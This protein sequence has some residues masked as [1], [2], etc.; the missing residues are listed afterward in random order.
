M[1]IFNS[2]V[3]L[4]EGSLFRDGESW[5]QHV[6]AP[7]SKRQQ[8]ERCTP[9]VYWLYLHSVVSPLVP[10]Y[11]LGSIWLM[12]PK[13]NV[14]AHDHHQIVSKIPLDLLQRSDSNASTDGSSISRYPLNQPLMGHQPSFLI[15]IWESSQSSRSRIHMSSRENPVHLSNYYCH[16]YR[17]WRGAYRLTAF[18]TAFR[19]HLFQKCMKRNTTV[20]FNHSH[21]DS[22]ITHA[23]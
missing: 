2:Y 12:T 19:A 18:H 17:F 4:P 15:F 14:I 20:V 9:L 6:P 23:Y 5:F 7:S 22:H 16:G 10:P 21:R 8:D 3:K 13:K 1:A 11:P